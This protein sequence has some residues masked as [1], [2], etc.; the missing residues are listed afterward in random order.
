MNDKHNEE[1]NKIPDIQESKKADMGL[2]K[3]STEGLDGMSGAFFQDT[4]DNIGE[5]IFQMVVAFF[6]WYELPKFVTYTNL[7]LLPQKI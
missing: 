3:N 5:D 2:N 1:L 6:C 4:W 7:V